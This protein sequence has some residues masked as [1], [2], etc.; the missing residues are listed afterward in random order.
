MDCSPLSMGFSR[1]EYWSGL[2]CPPPGNLPHPG[3]KSGSAALQADFFLNHLSYQGNPRRHGANRLFPGMRRST[4]WAV[5]LL[6]CQVA[7]GDPYTCL[8][9]TCLLP[10]CNR[11]QRLKTLVRWLTLHTHC[12][13]RNIE[14]IWSS[15]PRAST[16]SEMGLM[17]SVLIWKLCQKHILL[18]WK[19]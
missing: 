1:Q 6:Q 11:T 14:V 5:Q 10:L 19:Y 15:S 7:P 18:K 3:I 4:L 12:V 2:P 8:R 16:S 9:P 13:F 17:H